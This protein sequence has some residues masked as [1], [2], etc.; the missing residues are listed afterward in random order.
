MVV[1]R[2]AEF[3]AL[4]FRIPDHLIESAKQKEPSVAKKMKSEFVR[5]HPIR[6]GDGEEG[7]YFSP[8][9]Q[10]ALPK[11]LREPLVVNMIKYRKH[12]DEKI[13]AGDF[14]LNER[15]HEFY[16][17]IYT[18]MRPRWAMMMDIYGVQ[19]HTLE[20]WRRLALTLAGESIPGLQIEIIDFADPAPRVRTDKNMKALVAHVQTVA[21][22]MKKE[23][24]A[25][26]SKVTL[27]QVLKHVFNNRP[28]HLGKKRSTVRSF[29]SQYH[30]CVKACHQPMTLA[31]LGLR[32]KNERR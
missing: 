2:S 16:Q 4:L 11:S 29:E 14:D 18:K 26:S 30:Q 3:S 8:V 10:R 12:C 24:T 17:A 31:S 25:K 13:A 6:N 28:A 19:A 23:R 15:R 5:T 21:E 20:D 22:E 9:K 7:F 27:T 1:E 32:Y